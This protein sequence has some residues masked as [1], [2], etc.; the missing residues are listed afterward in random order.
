[1]SSKNIAKKETAGNKREK[2]FGEETVN[3]ALQRALFVPTED[4]AADKTSANK[5][6][7]N[8]YDLGNGQGKEN[9]GIVVMTEALDYKAVKSVKEHKK[10]KKETVSFLEVSPGQGRIL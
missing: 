7:K 3:T 5:Q 2:E 8:A 4:K 10:T 9:K 6:K 1:M